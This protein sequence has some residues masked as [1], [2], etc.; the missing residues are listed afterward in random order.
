MLCTA[1]WG[2]LCGGVARTRTGDGGDWQVERHAA[3]VVVVV[4]VA[5]VVAPPSAAAPCHAVNSSRQVTYALPPPQD[6]SV[7]PSMASLNS[8]TDN[9]KSDVASAS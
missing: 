4:I 6:V 3:M 7:I 5:G 8:V 1:A 2:R 9:L